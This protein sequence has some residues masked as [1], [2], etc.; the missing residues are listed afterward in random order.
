MRVHV[1]DAAEAPVFLQEG[2]YLTGVV[3]CPLATHDSSLV[4]VIGLG[5]E[6]A[7][8]V[9]NAR[10][11][12]VTAEEFARVVDTLK[13]ARNQVR[14]CLGGAA[15]FWSCCFCTK[16]AT[17]SLQPEPRIALRSSVIYLSKTRKERCSAS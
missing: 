10:M 3:S 4:S 2:V 17:Y 16:A 6:E 12:H 14:P 7:F 9:P 15:T 1:V 11:E 5:G 8:L 13:V